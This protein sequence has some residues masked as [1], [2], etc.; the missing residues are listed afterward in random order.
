MVKISLSALTSDMK[1]DMM[2]QYR[3]LPRWQAPECENCDEELEKRLGKFGNFWGCPNYYE[4]DCKFTQH[5]EYEDK[6]V[7]AGDYIKSRKYTH[8]NTRRVYTLKFHFQE[9][10]HRHLAALTDRFYEQLCENIPDWQRTID[11]CLIVP[12][13][14]IPTNP[15]QWVVDEIDGLEHLPLIQKTGKKKEAQ[16]GKG[17][18]ER[19]EAVKDGYQLIQSEDWHGSTVLILDDVVTTG[20]T[21]HEVGS[22]VIQASR[23]MPYGGALAKTRSIRK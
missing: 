1:Q 18:E 19:K 11:F 17:Y 16:K 20:S 21:M 23:M 10:G 12:C 22:L 15:I 7:K 3:T 9:E 5:Y 6:L 2:A 8:T 14:T 13:T 4:D